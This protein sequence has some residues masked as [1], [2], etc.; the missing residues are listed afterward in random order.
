MEECEIYYAG[1]IDAT[2][3][4]IYHAGTI[5]ATE[6]FKRFYHMLRRKFSDML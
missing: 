2:E 4:E 5:N 6:F 1:T 3:C